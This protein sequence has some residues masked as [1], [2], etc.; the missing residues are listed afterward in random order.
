[1]TEFLNRPWT[2]VHDDRLRRMAADGATVAE[3]ADAI[4][5]TEEGIRARLRELG[6]L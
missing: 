6:I 3:M 5:R 1:M 2:D 4:K